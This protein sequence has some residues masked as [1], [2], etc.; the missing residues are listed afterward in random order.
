M[1][2]FIFFFGNDLF[3]SRHN[4]GDKHRKSI[5]NA[6]NSN[7]FSSSKSTNST[8]SSASNGSSV[9]SD[10]LL[11]PIQGNENNSQELVVSERK[12]CLLFFSEHS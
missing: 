6:Q 2:H 7:S 1:F 12:A 4:T 10:S 3:I 9:L 5:K 8:M 11:Q